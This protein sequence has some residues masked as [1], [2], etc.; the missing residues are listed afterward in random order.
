MDI[1]I[2]ALVFL[3]MEVCQIHLVGFFVTRLA[4]GYP[5]GKF[6]VETQRVGC[7]RAALIGPQ[8]LA[9][10]F[11]RPALGGIQPGARHLDLDRS[12]RACQRSFP[13]SLAMPHHTGSFFIGGLLASSITRPGQGFIELSARVNHVVLGVCGATSGLPR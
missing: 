1:I 7:Q 13:T 12:E 8:R 6:F 10:P 9:L 4:L 2:L 5:G 3:A 11:G